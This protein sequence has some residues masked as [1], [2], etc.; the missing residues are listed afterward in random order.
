MKNDILMAVSNK[1][2]ISFTLRKSTHEAHVDL[3]L[4]PV[5][6][7]KPFLVYSR[8]VSLHIEFSFFPAL[9]I[10]VKKKEFDK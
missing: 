8:N 7:D 6:L 1:N 4:K 3:I 5:P 10:K 9:S 2:S